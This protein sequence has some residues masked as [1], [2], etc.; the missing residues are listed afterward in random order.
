MEP[1]DIEGREFFVGLRGYDRDE[2]DQFLAELAA[3]HRT[4][5]DELRDLRSRPEG[6]SSVARDP[7]EDLGANV[8][9]VLRTAN[10]SAATITAEAEATAADLREQAEQYAERVRQEAGED[11]LRILGDGEDELGRRRAELDAEAERLRNAAAETDAETERV[12]EEA[13]HHAREILERAHEEAGRLLNETDGRVSTIEADAEE[14]GRE[15]ARV[16]V[17]EAVFRLADATRRHEDLR[18]R[19]AESSDEI[20]LALMALGEP[21]AD[22]RQ[23]IDDAVRELLVLD[24]AEPVG[25]DG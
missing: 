14:R 23:A 21:I 2:V 7:F 4:L 9:A 18:A 3:E 1:Q 13:R 12:L 6:N 22:P 17:E 8:T 20:Q 10:E 16:R 25:H 5:L 19:L 11:A 15:R 24:D